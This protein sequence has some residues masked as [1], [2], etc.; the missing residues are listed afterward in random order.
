M[1]M[2]RL[3][4]DYLMLNH[5]VERNGL[6]PLL[7]T[8]SAPS[9]M[10]AFE[11]PLAAAGGLAR[12]ASPSDESSRVGEDLSPIAQ[13]ALRHLRQQEAR[14]SSQ[15][16]HP[17][18]ASPSRTFPNSHR[19]D[20]VQRTTPPLVKSLHEVCL[21]SYTGWFDEEGE[22]ASSANAGGEARHRPE[23]QQQQPPRE[24]YAPKRHALFVSADEHGNFEQ[25]MRRMITVRPPT[26]L[27]LDEERPSSD[28]SESFPVAL[29][30]LRHTASWD[31][32]PPAMAVTDFELNPDARSQT[33]R[34]DFPN[35]TGA[36]FTDLA[37]N[38][39]EDEFAARERENKANVRD[40]RIHKNRITN[41]EDAWRAFESERSV[42]EAEAAQGEAADVDSLIDPERARARRAAKW[43]RHVDSRRNTTRPDAVLEQDQ[44]IDREVLNEL[45]GWAETYQAPPNYEHR[46]KTPDYKNG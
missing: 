9:S 43:K 35:E 13:A 25:R 20:S 33:A 29:Y 12:S 4:D 17:S 18:T 3:G 1:K 14:S 8:P 7:L 46:S 31:F 2:H 40:A 44:T 15:P 41:D 24:P 36:P 38:L 6:E 22:H 45:R 34:R 28:L 30:Q 23:P 42:L 26:V 32:L 21:D 5:V 10:R 11:P 27:L 37:R 16:P 19:D 39:S